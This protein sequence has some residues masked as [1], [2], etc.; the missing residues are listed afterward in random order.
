VVSEDASYADFASQFSSGRIPLGYSKNDGRCVALPLKQMSRF[1]IY[2]GDPRGVL[3]VTENFFLAAQRES[4]DILVVKRRK[5]SI[6]DGALGKAKGVQLVGCDAES[7]TELWQVVGN[8]STGRK[9]QIQAYLKEKNLDEKAADKAFSFLRSKTTAVLI[10]IENFAD[11]AATLDMTAQ[12]VFEKIFETIRYR[13]IYVVG[14]F[15]PNRSSA[16]M[17]SLYNTYPTV[18]SA[19]LF[20]GNYDGQKF[21]DL[22]SYKAGKDARF[23]SC[24]M[25]YKGT[26]YP[27]LMPCGEIAAEET[28]PDDELIF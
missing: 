20:G 3:P 24:I 22:S 8:E 15:E 12:M 4:M 14:C 17:P 5:D 7:L 9:A 6:F 25:R 10:W 26:L 18:G 16:P 21:V 19:M 13:N 2:F 11:F 1:S 23:N 28:D 27:L